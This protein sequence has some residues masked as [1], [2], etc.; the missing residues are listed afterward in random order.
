MFW[1]SRVALIQLGLAPS[2]TTA[3]SPKR[4]NN[5]KSRHALRLSSIPSISSAL[6]R[7][8]L[9]PL[10]SQAH[11]CDPARRSRPT[12]ECS[13]EGTVVFR[14]LAPCPS[15]VILCSFFLRCGISL[16]LV[17]DCLLVS[18]ALIYCGGKTRHD[19]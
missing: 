13:V 11:S 10:I 14:Y 15:T 1:A 19:R 6:Q 4:T 9:T 3:R 16:Y 12:P 5:L 2:V 18:S 7:Y 8:H 17:A